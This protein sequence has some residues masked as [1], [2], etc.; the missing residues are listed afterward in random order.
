M[1]NLL[2]LSYD[3]RKK[4]L[5]RVQY[6]GLTGLGWVLRG[7]TRILFGE[8]TWRGFSALSATEWLRKSTRYSL[9]DSTIKGIDQ[10]LKE[11]LSPEEAL[12]RLARKAG[13]SKKEI[14]ASKLPG[15]GEPI[16]DFIPT[17]E[18]ILAKRTALEIS[19]ANS[20]KKS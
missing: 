16:P 9:P 1:K 20:I 14:K 6:Y 5:D 17:D 12:D 18:E 19:I 11:N 13:V 7:L 8:E 4:L 10:A 15:R 2:K 3:S